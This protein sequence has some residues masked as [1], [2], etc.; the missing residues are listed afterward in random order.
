MQ[1]NDNGVVIFFDAVVYFVNWMW[2]YNISDK[3]VPEEL[4]MMAHGCT[5]CL[6]H[7]QKQKVLC[8]FP[9]DL[10]RSSFCSLIS[11]SKSPHLC[12]IQWCSSLLSRNK[13]GPNLS[14][15]FVSFLFSFLL[16]SLCESHSWFL[17]NSLFNALNSL[18]S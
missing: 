3:D 12:S 7:S 2:E 15:S 6:N 4:Q 17:F 14:F 11:E 13:V 5:N 1:K 18:W 16:W 10:K 9:T 8:S